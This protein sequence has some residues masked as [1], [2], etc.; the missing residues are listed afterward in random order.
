MSS[1]RPFDHSDHR[2]QLHTGALP[3]DRRAGLQDW[4]L[5]IPWV[6]RG[7][8]AADVPQHI[9]IDCPPLHLKCVWLVVMSEPD[10]LEWDLFIV[11]PMAMTRLVRGLDWF[12]GIMPLGSGQCLC[13][14]DL[15]RD[16]AELELVLLAT[17]GMLFPGFADGGRT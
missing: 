17:Y 1:D 3:A 12:T 2:S 4:I 14:V 13:R 10:R 11:V 8:T 15:E 5:G 16:A 9:V 6:V 7:H